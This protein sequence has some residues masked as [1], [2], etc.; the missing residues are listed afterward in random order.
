MGWIWREKP[1]GSR[2]LAYPVYLAG[3]L[4]A[5]GLIAVLHRRLAPLPTQVAAR[6][7]ARGAEVSAVTGAAALAAPV[8]N[9]ARPATGASKS[10]RLAHQPAP[11]AVPTVN[12]E[13][14]S[15]DAID[16]TLQ[17][18]EAE[19]KRRR[20]S[21]HSAFAALPPAFEGEGAPRTTL[22][23]YRDPSADGNGPP[24]R[25]VTAPVVLLARGSLLPVFL[26]TSVDTSNPAA[27]LQFGL[28]DDVVQHGSC[29]LRLGT[30]LL[31]KLGGRPMRGRLELKVDTVLY[32]EGTQRPIAA[33][34]VEA[35]ELGSDIRPGVAA[36]FVP[37]PAWA[38]TVPYLSDFATGFL[39]LL[40]S[41]AQERLAVGS[42]GLTLQ[43]SVPNEMQ[44]S[45]GQAGAQAIN[46][47]TRSRLREIEDRYAAYY[48]I[49]AG[50]ECWMQLD[51]DFVA[52][53]P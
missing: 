44:G 50:T 21:A 4:A 51:A 47:F 5:L 37:T 10:F 14:E 53:S 9:S 40:Q 2:A 22:L 30:H 35:N 18:A 43:P 7:N 48:Y 31:G 3:A 23:G 20:D 13:S 12:A 42:A 11:V 39:G 24:P 26:L 52:V 36:T 46:D 41:R 6:T 19:E 49:P 27:V 1:D 34:A 17:P 33:T 38:Q 45:A 28:A 15:F 8:P 16:A 29:R 25:P 32:P